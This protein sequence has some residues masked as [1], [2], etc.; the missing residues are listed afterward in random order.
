MNDPRKQ[1]I[2]DLI[3]L[4]RKETRTATLF[5]QTVAESSGIHITDTKCL[6]F[7]TTAQSATAGDLAK[8]TGLT[9]GAITAV[10]DRMEKA[11]FIKRVAD[12]NDRRKIIIK[13]LIKHPKHLQ[14]AHNLFANQMPK[15]L[16][17]YT[18]DEIAIITDWNSKLISL[19]QDEIKKLEDLKQKK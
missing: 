11:G 8:V 16:S 2:S 19:F 12:S 1:S 15:I 13:L 6:D 18:S 3:A 7:L 14:I 4:I 9:T 10:I 5:V 17:E